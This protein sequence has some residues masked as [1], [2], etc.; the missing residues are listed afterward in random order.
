MTKLGN[1]FFGQQKDRWIARVPVKAHLRRTNGTYWVKED[2]LESTTVPS[3]GEL[4]F[5]ASMSEAEQR[6]EVRRQ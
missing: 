5:P 2:W 6:A 1:E 3:L 4:A